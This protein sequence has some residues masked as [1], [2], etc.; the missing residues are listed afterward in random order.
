MNPNIDHKDTKTQR[1]EISL[2]ANELTRLMVDSAYAVHLT[3]GSRYKPEFN[4]N[5]PRIKD[6]IKRLVL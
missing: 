4:L 3:L 2:Q 6:G 5:T 1:E